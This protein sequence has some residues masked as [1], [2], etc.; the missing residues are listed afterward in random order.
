[1]VCPRCKKKLVEDV[2][3]NE[4]LDVCRSCGGLWLHK[5]QLNSLLKESG[6]DVESLSITETAEKDKYPV[7][8]CRHCTA[9]KMKKIHFLEYSDVVMDY[10][11]SCGA[12]WLD[13]NE[14][15]KMHEYVKRIDEGSHEVKNRSGFE[16]LIKLNK[17]A[18]L[19]FH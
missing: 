17:I 3:E 11:P 16:V 7:I 15:E 14:L 12:F 10:C 19:I 1:M 18:Y 6:G 2:R 13:K 9:V 5:D 8:H 4:R